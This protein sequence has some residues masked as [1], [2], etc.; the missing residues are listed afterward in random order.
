MPTALISKCTLSLRVQHLAQLVCMGLCGSLSA[1][2]TMDT[3]VEEEEETFEAYELTVSS[4]SPAASHSVTSNCTAHGYDLGRF[5]PDRRLRSC[6]G[7]VPG[8][9][10]AA[11]LQVRYSCAYR[12]CTRSADR[13]RLGVLLTWSGQAD[14]VPRRSRQQVKSGRSKALNHQLCAPSLRVIV[15]VRALATETERARPAGITGGNRHGACSK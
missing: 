7:A 2:E 9:R 4:A 1:P 12:Q 3:V 15:A 5:S 6:C 10:P 11:S 8:A 14:S 13:D